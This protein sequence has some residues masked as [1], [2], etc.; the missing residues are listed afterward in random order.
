[1]SH[2]Y[3]QEQ[4]SGQAELPRFGAIVGATRAGT[5][6]ALPRQAVR[7]AARAINLVKCLAHGLDEVLARFHRDACR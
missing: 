6:G 5:R 7:L 4:D 1:M 2:W 3:T